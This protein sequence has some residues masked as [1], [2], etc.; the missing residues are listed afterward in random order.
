M[1][2]PLIPTPERIRRKERIEELLR[3][4]YAPLKV[5]G[6]KG[7][8]CNHAALAEDIN[9]HRWVRSEE[10]ERDAGRESYVPDWSLYAGEIQPEAP[11]VTVMGDDLKPTQIEH[12]QA[13]AAL[14][15]TQVNNLVT[16]SRFP[17]INPDAIIIA[18]NMNQAYDVMLG[19]YVERQGRP[20]TWLTDTLRVAP[21]PDARNRRFLFTAAQNDAPL[22]D[23]FW[24]NLQAY[25]EHIGAEIVVGPFTYETTWWSE[26][27]PT[28]REYA[29]ELTEHLCFGQMEIG[30]NFIFAGEMNT[31]PTASQPIS[32]L[33]TYSRN[34]WAVFPHA[35]RQLKSVPSTDPAV[36]A[37]Q[38]MTTGSVTRPKVIPRKAGVKSLF[39]QVV[40]AVVVE[41][42]EEANP[43]CRQITANE[44]GSFYDLDRHISG[45][46]VT[47]G[48]RVR[49]VVAAD[50][51]MRKIANDNALATFGFDPSTQARYRGSLIDVLRP[52]YLMLHDIFDHEAR[53]HH[54]QNDPGHAYEMHV[55][56]RASILG[57]IVQVGGFLEKLQVT[58]PETEIVVVESNHDIGLDRYVREG[59]Y[60]QDPV[61]IRLGLKLE[62]AM[63][64]QRAAVAMALDND[65]T[66]PRF[67]LLE[68][69]LR[70][71]GAELDRVSWAYDGYSRLIDG[72]EVGHHGFRG[73]NGSKGTVQGF[74]RTGR[75]MSI[76]DKHSPEINEGV[77]VAG[78]INLQMGYNRGPSTWAVSH[79][80]H[81]A[82]GNRS[83]VTLQKGRWR[84]EKPRVSVPASRAA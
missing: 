44:D 35:K 10:R 80:I 53:N 68:A 66:P 75:K 62:D 37:H 45:G 67:S 23:G 4:G 71:T 24:L 21:V 41:F 63:L 36:Q 5:R 52:E 8:A 69:A 54:N 77:Y 31:L 11:H 56:G 29:E 27:D 15:A 28:S 40:G 26:N 34:R 58:V 18:S 70:G 19:E 17:L 60:R 48:H 55:R 13:R 76:G 30:D 81:Y 59:R 6:G 84:A 32:D 73:V 83:I 79:I 16:R 9:Y 3:Q 51:H 57:E 38:V 22:H 12:A 20:R 50:L 78:A 65:Q 61:N 49:A 43:F 39:H 7:A 47:T 74:A 64:G 72:I 33:T 46:E 2:T 1:P 14:L 25:A 42:D 82:D